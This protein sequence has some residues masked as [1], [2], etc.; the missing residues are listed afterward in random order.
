MAEVRFYTIL[1]ILCLLL[2]AV[3][4]P[5]AA[6]TMTSSPLEMTTERPG[7]RLN[8]V[9]SPRLIY[10]TINGQ[11]VLVI[12]FS[13]WYQTNPDKPPN[14]AIY[15]AVCSAPNACGT[16]Q[17]V[18]DPVADNMGSA[19]LVNNPTI[20]ELH[21]FSRPYL[22]MYM[23]GVAGDDRNAAWTTQN[24]KIYYSMSWADD[25]VNWSVPQLLIDSAWLP[26]A[27]VDA[28]GNVILYANTNWN[29]NPYFLARWNLGRSGIAVTAPQPIVADNEA[30]YINVEAKYR[31]QIGRFQMVAQQVT[32]GF[33]S[34][35]DLLESLDGVNWNVRAENIT[36]QG[37]TPGVHPDTSCWVYYGKAPQIYLSNI[38]LKVWC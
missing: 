1:R 8:D 7:T 36:P 5:G 15:R 32:A 2:L 29:N 20:V 30:N 6:Q 19:A 34:E 31:P 14:D 26:S 25:G 18:I 23:T 37:M 17:K 13:G 21:N 12:Y 35:I 10:Q 9:Y 33:N 4:R 3:S 27:T 28:D 24:N 16:V 11:K 38:F 22:V